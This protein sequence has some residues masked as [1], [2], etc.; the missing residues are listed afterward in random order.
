MHNYFILC[1]RKYSGQHEYAT[2]F[3]R[4]DWL[5]FLCH[6]IKPDIPTLQWHIPDFNTASVRFAVFVAGVRKRTH[7]ECEKQTCPS[8]LVALCQFCIVKV[9]YLRNSL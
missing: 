5:R 8:I 9:N 6:G 7:K 1:H 2:A 4:S 3:L